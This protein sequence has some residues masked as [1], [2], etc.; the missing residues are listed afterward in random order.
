MARVAGPGQ[1]FEWRMIAPESDVDENRHISNIA[2]LRWIQD[3]TRA[4]SDAVGWPRERYHALGCVF[5]IR[6]HEVDYLRSAV[7]GD[8]IKI[9]TWAEE[10]RQASA[11]RMTR[12]LRARDDTELVVARTEWVFV[13]IDGMRPRRI[14]AEVTASFAGPLPAPVSAP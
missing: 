1:P 12:I 8:E 9:V 14:P 2:Y 10:L 11:I 6:R 13:S 3:S 4:H 7:G 5:V